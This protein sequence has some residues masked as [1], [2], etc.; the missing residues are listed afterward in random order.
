MLTPSQFETAC[1][2]WSADLSKSFSIYESPLDDLRRVYGA[3]KHF[4]ILTTKN[5]INFFK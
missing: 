2:M 5:N 1:C 4:L 3:P